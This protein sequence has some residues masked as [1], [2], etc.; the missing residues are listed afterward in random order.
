MGVIS[1]V[2]LL[3]ANSS[4][5]QAALGEKIAETEQPNKKQHLLDMCRTRWIQR[6][7]AFENFGQFYEV[8]V[9]VL[10]DI[11]HSHG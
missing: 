2:A 5:R 8:V 3:I 4:K 1:K 11:R 6:H 9:E 10:E 7:E